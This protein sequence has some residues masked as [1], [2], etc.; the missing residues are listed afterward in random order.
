MPPLLPSCTPVPSSA[1]RVDCPGPI[2][3]LTVVTFAFLSTSRQFVSVCGVVERLASTTTSRTG[4]I[5]Q[6]ALDIDR[7]R[8]DGRRRWWWWRSSGYELAERRRARSGVTGGVG[9]NPL[10]L[11]TEKET[12][13]PIGKLQDQSAV[14]KH[15][16]VGGVL[17]D[18]ALVHV[19]V[20]NPVETIRVAELGIDWFVQVLIEFRAECVDL[21][22]GRLALVEIQGQ[23]VLQV[24][25]ARAARW[26]QRSAGVVVSDARSGWPASGSTTQNA[27]FEPPSDCTLTAIR[28]GW[29]ESSRA[30]T[31]RCGVDAL[32]SRLYL[33][34]RARSTPY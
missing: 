27:T 24:V 29:P 19:D 7:G 17:P 10:R 2:V 22:V 25:A 12:E 1:I 21:A 26:R 5:D 11:E 4:R 30:R 16:V 34:G 3:V 18:V 15:A 32:S 6:R 13:I 14:V 28:H 8:G 9:R 20:V 33:S 23:E 31:C